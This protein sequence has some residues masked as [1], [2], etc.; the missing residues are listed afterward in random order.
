MPLPR[1]FTLLLARLTLRARLPLIAFAALT[2]PVALLLAGLL[3]VGLLAAL[4]GL[5]DFALQLIGE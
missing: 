4:G 5:R 3:T 2:G 1:L